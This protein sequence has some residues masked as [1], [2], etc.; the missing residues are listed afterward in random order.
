MA[1]SR[2]RGLAGVLAVFALFLFP[3]LPT[4][5]DVQPGLDSI[6]RDLD[7][8][9]VDLH[10]NPELS[11][12]ERETSAKL[13]GKLRALGY[14]VTVGVGGH[15]IVGVLRN[16]PGP[17]VLLRTDM[18]ALP[19][20]EATGLPYAST[21]VAKNPQGE[22]VPVS[23]MCGHDIHMTSWIGAA[24]LL[25]SSRSE[26]RGTVVLVG[27]PAEELV[28]G[29]AS[30]LA[31]G[32]LT[33]F[34]RP[35]Y[36]IAI[37][38][39]MLVPAGKVGLAPGFAMANNDF[40]D[41]TVFGKGGHGAAPHRTVDPVLIAARTVAALQS[42]VAR[43]VNPLD[44]AVVTV[45]SIHGGTKHNVIPE[46]VKLQLT[47]RSYK[48]EV[49]KQLL[50][51]IARIAKA[52]AAAAGAPREPTVVVVAGASAQSLFNDPE[53]MARL[54]K[55]LGAALGA[56]NVVPTGPVMPSEDFGAFGRAANIPSALLWVGAA[57]PEAFARAEA[58]GVPLP[59]WHTP[60]FAPD[61]ERTIR[62][63]VVAFTAS[64]LAVLGRP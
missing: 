36:A 50:A 25:S 41:I 11:L 28:T 38:D 35:D 46:E 13:A 49:Q 17:T 27:Q 39:T 43:E 37:H 19:V 2:R 56:S 21:V 6:Y 54:G 7:A 22:T 60:F 40:V 32:F 59:N 62:T 8:L 47:V 3:R 63:G 33:R 16:G 53:L 4:A 29:A 9:Y 18:D 51:A 52:E 30:M 31:D 1:Q 26:W 42:I 48:P 24:T 14:E 12:Q 34:P 23:H 44:P 64:A 55:A 5:M 57:D 61:R 20:K 10:R 45:G 58:S 15:G